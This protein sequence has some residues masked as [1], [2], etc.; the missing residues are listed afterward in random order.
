MLAFFDDFGLE[1]ENPA[2]AF[3]KD[4]LHATTIATVSDV[5]YM[6]KIS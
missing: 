5:C 6:Q 3:R 2:E 4:L 1:S